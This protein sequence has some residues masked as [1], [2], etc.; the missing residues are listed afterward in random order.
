MLPVLHFPADR[1]ILPYSRIS[2]AS[3]RCAC[4]LRRNRV[5]SEFLPADL[6]SSCIPHLRK[7]AFPPKREGRPVV[8]YKGCDQTSFEY[9]PETQPT[10]PPTMT[11][12]QPFSAVAT[13]SNEVP[14]FAAVIRPYCVPLPTRM[15]TVPPSQTMRTRLA[16]DGSEGS[17][18]S[19]G[20]FP[21]S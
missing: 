10:R 15:L 11:A 6:V 1:M 17:S 9:F 19:A 21:A 14:S 16:M 18:G 13:H 12:C 2:P 5:A 20:S 7:A 4:N 3:R 8:C